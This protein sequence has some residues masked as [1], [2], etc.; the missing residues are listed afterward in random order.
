[1]QTKPKKGTRTAA[2]RKEAIKEE[3]QRWKIIRLVDIE[4]QLKALVGEKAE[5]QGVQ[6]PA[7]KAIIHYKSPVVAIIGTGGG[8][9]VLFMLP[10]LC[11]T[12]VTVVVM[13]LVS[14]Q[15]DIKSRCNK[16]G[17]SCVE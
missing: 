13:L 12:G 10:A 7:L 1:M 14:L 8:K 9:S 16:A 11:S 17:I 5:F 15:E 2:N 3:Y 4:Q 6:R